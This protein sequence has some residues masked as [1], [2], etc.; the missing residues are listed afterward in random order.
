[1]SAD[2][3]SQT[4]ATATEFRLT[5][6]PDRHRREIIRHRRAGA[7]LRHTPDAGMDETPGIERQMPGHN[8]GHSIFS[9]FLIGSGPRLGEAVSV[10]EQAVARAEIERLRRIQARRGCCGAGLRLW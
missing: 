2:R 1:M 6:A 9:V 8:F 3:R 4:A 7:E 5:H 10:K